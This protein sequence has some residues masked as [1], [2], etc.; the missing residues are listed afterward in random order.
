MA[1]KF[2]I[3]GV[4][5]GIDKMTAPV[6]KMGKSIATFGRRSVAR[7]K[8]L[9]KSIGKVGGI[10]ASIGKRAALFGG[11]AIGAIGLL[12]KKTADLGDNL[13]KLGRRVGFTVEELQQWRQVAELAGIDQ[14]AFDD[15]LSGFSKRLGEAKVGTGSLVTFLKKFDKQLLKQLVTTKGNGKAFE[16]LVDKLRD[17]KDPALKSALAMAAFGRSGLRFVNIAD[18]SKEAIKKQRMEMVRF[19]QISQKSAEENEVFNDALTRMRRAFEGVGFSIASV[20]IPRLTPLIDKVTGFIVDSR[21]QIQAWLKQFAERIPAA[22]DIASNGAMKLWKGFQSLTQG[23]GSFFGGI[24]FEGLINGL[25]SVFNIMVKVINLIGDIVPKLTPMIDFFSSNLFQGLASTLG[26][27]LKLASEVADIVLALVDLPLSIG[28]FIG[29]SVAK[30][31]LHAESSQ[32]DRMALIDQADAQMVTPQERTARSIEEHR[33]TSTAELLIR[34]Q[35]G[36]AELT[37]K[38]APGIDLELLPTGA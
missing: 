23:A 1:N 15:S 38:T 4:F 14:K 28:R 29:R 11:V 8:T 20:L 30:I 10:M 37:G 3:E 26:F 9:G 12:I 22:F 24:S 36:R 33:Q 35:T 19:G 34:D 21:P 31:V 18:S 16:V 27:V 7:M 25:L 2:S 13:A 6:R 17:V 5:K 32:A